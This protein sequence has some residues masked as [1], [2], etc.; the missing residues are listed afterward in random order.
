MQNSRKTGVIIIALFLLSA[1]LSVPVRAQSD[2]N[3]EPILTHANNDS[4]SLINQSNLA[5]KLSHKHKDSA[6]NII[7]D[8][9]EEAQI[10][11][12]RS[13]EANAIKK[14]ASVYWEYGDYPLA[15]DNF[16]KA[17]NLFTEM[18]N[19]RLMS[20][21]LI[22]I[23]V[24]YGV[25]GEYPMALDY[26]HQAIDGLDTTKDLNAF[27]ACLTN[28]GIIHKKQKNL[29]LAL[30]YQKRALRIDSLLQDT[31]GLIKVYTNL[32][33][34]HLDLT[35]QKQTAKHY[36]TKAIELCLLTDNQRSLGVAMTNMGE[37]YL[38]QGNM[39]SAAYFFKYS[40]QHNKLYSP[41]SASLSYKNYAR[42]LIEKAK[43][44]KDDAA[45]AILLKNAI[46]YLDS[47][48]QLAKENDILASQVLA[49]RYKTQAYKML[50]ACEK[51]LEASMMLY[52]L[53]DSLMSKDK[54]QE[55]EHLEARYQFQQQLQK[56]NQ[57]NLAKDQANKTIQE[58][59][60]ALYLSVIFAAILL[61]LIVIM[62]RLNSQRRKA[63]KA[64][65]WFNKE[66]KERSEELAAQRDEIEDYATE[67]ERINKTR[68]RLYSIIAHDL[69]GPYNSL[70]GFTDI[71]MTDWNSLSEDERISMI[72]LINK[73]S[74]EN[75]NLVLNLLEW[76]RFQSGK[77][78]L[79]P[80]QLNIGDTL[81]NIREQMLTS[82][83]L[84]K[85]KLQIS[86]G[87][88]I[89]AK[90]D[91]HL[92]ST[93]LRNLISNAIKFTHKG[94]EIQLEA[95][96]K[97][98]Q[99]SI[100]VQDN[101]IGMS[102]YQLDQIKNQGELESQTGTEGENGTGLGI[103]I[104]FEFAQKMGGYIEIDSTKGKGSC[105]RLVLTT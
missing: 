48:Y 76:S 97:D 65:A 7:K 1:L 78:S 58:Q 93:V 38:D 29:N 96:E 3:M 30:Q 51:A 75:Y 79:N 66:I 103:K 49:M 77:I 95:F 89:T 70:L 19:G 94:G 10:K 32:A 74:A 68:D 60:R 27:S 101:G 102:D 80:Q 50:G 99:I 13:I 83:E 39:D 52:D 24:I 6:L 91:E 5:Y 31:I 26:F 20:Q 23:A 2:D 4:I 81:S 44:K 67:L 17:A 35:D 25:K 18:G 71:L 53:N 105:F 14:L 37:L 11:N 88:Q 9:I 45:Q 54:M 47:C 92:L 40:L 33:S 104:C 59:E 86:S 69:K 84:K 62:I 64:L 34:I 87:Q 43:R 63:N 15:L 36:L 8:I 22:G 56:I 98:G 41:K 28:I 61:V 73:T 82:A 46:L 90:L 16:K 72:S 55:I 57:L 42:L 12:Y 85:I 21:S 100:S